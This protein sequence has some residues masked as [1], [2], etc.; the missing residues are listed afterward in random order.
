MGLAWWLSNTVT[1]SKGYFH[2]LPSRT[3]LVP[4]KISLA[5]V[6]QL[7][8]RLRDSTT[9]NASDIAM[10]LHLREEQKDQI[11]LNTHEL[12]NFCSTRNIVVPPSEELLPKELI[13]FANRLVQL[14]NRFNQEK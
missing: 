6:E 13:D 1:T 7:E 12:V 2:F 5:E 10:I 9:P 14:R 8:T 4:R 11:M 3:T